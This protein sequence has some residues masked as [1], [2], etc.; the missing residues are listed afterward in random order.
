MFRTPKF[1]DFG[2]SYNTTSY[3]SLQQKTDYSFFGKTATYRVNPPVTEGD[4]ETL[5]L[6]VNFNRKNII[7][8]Q[9][10]SFQWW[11][12]AELTDVLDLNSDSYFNKYEAE[13]KWF[14]YLDEGTLLKW[15][16]RAGAVTG[17]TPLQKQFELGGIGTM[18]ATPHKFYKGNAMALSNIELH[19]GSSNVMGD[20]EWIDADDLSLSFFL[21]SGWTQWENKL[22]SEDDPLKGFD[23]F[24]VK[25]MNHD[26]GI[27][28]GTNLFRAELA[29][30]INSIGKG[31]PALWF[32]FN[33][34]F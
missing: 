15:R 9:F 28:L 12:K 2:V 10:V 27:G 6:G 3:S 13:W 14:F 23:T 25:D 7:I 1:M 17:D 34:T 21:D 31:T 32:R 24:T 5:S 33:P 19:F 30:P 8:S 18:R 16:L 11:V 26:A 29:W 22:L 4:Y 20:M